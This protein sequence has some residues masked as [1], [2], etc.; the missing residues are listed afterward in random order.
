MAALCHDL[1]HFPLSHTLEAVFDRVYWRYYSLPKYLPGR[2]CHETISAEVVRWLGFVEEAAPL[3]DKAVARGV[4]LLLMCPDNVRS[5]EGDI[6]IERSVF[7][8]LASLIGGDFDV[9]RLDYLQRDG[10]LSG[11]GFGRVDVTRLLDSMRI[12]EENGTFSV[13]P[14]SKSISTLESVLLERYKETKWVV[15]HHKVLYFDEVT[16]QL[17]RS[18]LSD[19]EFQKKAF[20]PSSVHG[21]GN[22]D[23]LETVLQSLGN[24]QMPIP[25]LN[26]Y[27]GD[28][29]SSREH[30]LNVPFFIEDEDTRFLDD[31]WFCLACRNHRSERRTGW[32]HYYTDVLVDRQKCGLTLWKD[33][34]QFEAFHKLCVDRLLNDLRSQLEELVG[35]VHAEEELRKRVGYWLSAVWAELSEPE[36][37]AF[38]ALWPRLRNNLTDQIPY[39]DGTTQPLVEPMIKTVRW[40]KL[41][42]D[43]RS[44]KLVDRQGGVSSVAKH[45]SLLAGLTGAGGEIPFFLYLTGPAGHV[46]EYLE[47]CEDNPDKPLTDMAEG[48]TIGLLACWKSD[49]TKP[50]LDGAWKQAEGRY[51]QGSS[52]RADKEG[53]FDDTR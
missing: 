42:K 40:G 28:V 34:G 16:Q 2:A 14:T 44:S 51:Y 7:P 24:P 48:L 15:Y 12:V 46:Q 43:M 32:R 4:I 1:G 53:A 47:T 41:F 36:M 37:A 33:L 38:D 52:T 31:L 35:Q 18:L 10:H 9:D 27:T 19:S 8:A 11:T 22:D 17:A 30:M 50:V 45:S 3:I 20:K 49:E 5:G 29:F 39:E 25:P 26:L 21:N 13:L 6:G 23:Y